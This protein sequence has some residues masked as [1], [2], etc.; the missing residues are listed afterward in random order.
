MMH[1][2]ETLCREK[3]R[4]KIAPSTFQIDGNQIKGELHGIGSSGPSDS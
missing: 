4:L 2:V 1:G 3:S